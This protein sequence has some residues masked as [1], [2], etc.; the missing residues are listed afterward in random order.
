MK[1]INVLMCGSK[2]HV[3]GGMVSVIKN[4]LDIK[5]W[6]EYEIIYIPTHTENTTHTKIDKLITM[7]YF[8]IEYIR[9]FVMIPIKKFKIAHLHSAERGSFYRKAMLARML[10]A[11]GVK[12]ILHHHAA[13]FEEFY[14]G[15]S[16]KKKQ[17]VNATLEMVDVNIVLSSSLI[18]MIKSKAPKANVVVLYNAVETYEKNPYNKEA[19]NVLFLGRLGKRKGTYD[20]LDA[21]VHIDKE[22]PLDVKFYLCGDGEVES[23]RSKIR[24]YG[25]EHRVAHLGWIDMEQKKQFMGQT[26]VNVLPSYNEGLPMSI[27][28]TMAY[29]IPNIS[30]DIASIPEVVIEGK[31]GCLIKAGDV[32]AIEDALT[33]MIED[34]EYRYH[35]SEES[36]NLIRK[37]FN[38]LNNIAKVKVLYAKILA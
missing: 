13:E 37:K 21:I 4:Y 12:V 29:G 22:L 2:L 10:K 8:C 28:E 30:T 19:L 17:F 26:A 9:I 34:R 31:T 6:G 25:I 35:C 7:L 27:L 14:D 5:D 38:L 16:K 36:Y 33:K 24:E 11:F 1:K 20:L 15:L 3:K 23:I 18:S 32:K